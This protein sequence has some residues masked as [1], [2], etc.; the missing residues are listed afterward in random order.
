MPCALELS[1]PEMLP[2]G[3]GIIARRVLRPCL[4]M[5]QVDLST[6]SIRPGRDI[7]WLRNLKVNTLAAVEASQADLTVHTSNWAHDLDQVQQL[8]AGICNR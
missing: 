4:A 7:E 6:S 3:Y 2:F 5:L 8:C 1:Q